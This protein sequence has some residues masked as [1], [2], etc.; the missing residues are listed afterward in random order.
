LRHLR[1]VTGYSQRTL[2][3][4]LGISKSALGYLEGK[5]WKNLSMGEL[6]LYARGFD[7]SLEELISYLH[8]SLD[9]N[10]VFCNSQNPFS[11]WIYQEGIR[12]E[13]HLK[14]PSRL[15]FGKLILSPQKSLDGSLAPKAEVIVYHV[16][17]GKIF[18]KMGPKERVF[19]EGESFSIKSSSF[20]ELY[21]PHQFK[22][23]V[24]ILSTTPSFIRKNS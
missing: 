8:H 15:F 23:A 17:T 4:K 21:N 3:K 6:E 16:L 11:S 13:S 20:Y 9:E 2:A 1:E 14:N 12:F 10:L 18:F 24:L 22:D 19:G 5:S 7:M